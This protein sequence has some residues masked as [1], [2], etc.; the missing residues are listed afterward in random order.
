MMALTLGLVRG[1]M[2]SLPSNT[3]TPQ[4][5]ATTIIIEVSLTSND[6]MMPEMTTEIVSMTEPASITSQIMQTTT[7][8]PMP[9]LTPTPTPD[10]PVVM[11]TTTTISSEASSFS[12]ATSPTMVAMTSPTPTIGEV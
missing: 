10:V 4:P 3:V 6:M 5:S 11:P 12:V 8:V 7:M 2:S 1:Q 9:T